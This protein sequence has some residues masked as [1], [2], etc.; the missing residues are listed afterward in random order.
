MD[1]VGKVGGVG[2]RV[3]GEAVGEALRIATGEAVVGEA[4]GEALGVSVGEAV[5]ETEGKSVGESV[6]ESEGD[7]VGKSVHF[8]SMVTTAMALRQSKIAAGKSPTP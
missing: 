6:G 7:D 1:G 4:V 3:D 2:A 5:G 8:P